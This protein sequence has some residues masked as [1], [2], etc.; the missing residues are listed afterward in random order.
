MNTLKV[1]GPWGM[2]SCVLAG[3]AVMGIMAPGD[4][5]VGYIYTGERWE[6]QDNARLVACAPELLKFVVEAW[7]YLD[8]ECEGGFVEWNDYVTARKLAVRAKGLIDKIGGSNE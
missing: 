6:D 5:L 1:R 7:S 2:E 4:G 8:G 3:D